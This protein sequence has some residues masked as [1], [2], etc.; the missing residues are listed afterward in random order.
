M[1]WKC[2]EGR[3]PQ[4]HAVQFESS[5]EVEVATNGDC[6]LLFSGVL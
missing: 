4:A 3:N 6:T 2:C 5:R 1:A